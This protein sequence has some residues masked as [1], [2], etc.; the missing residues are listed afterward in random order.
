M[1]TVKFYGLLRLESGFKELNMDAKN[2]KELFDALKRQG[3]DAKTLRGCSILING[4]LSPGHTRLQEGD[5]VIL[6]S[7]EHLNSG[8]AFPV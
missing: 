1:I 6:Y 4:K 3:F 8:D 7:K 5:T 2:T